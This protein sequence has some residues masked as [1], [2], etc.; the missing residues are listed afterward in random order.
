MGV[1]EM[2]PVFKVAMGRHVETLAQ[3]FI[4]KQTLIRMSCHYSCSVYIHEILDTALKTESVFSF[5][6]EYVTRIH[7]HKTVSTIK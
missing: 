6:K 2:V 5:L 7:L 4:P 3:V 1:T